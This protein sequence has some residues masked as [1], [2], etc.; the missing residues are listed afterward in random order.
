MSEFVTALL[1]SGGIFVMMMLTQLGRRKY[2]VARILIP[3]A[4]LAYFG[5]TYL[6]DAPL[7]GADLV[8]YGVA[9]LIGAVFAVLA[10]VT[11]K[12]EKDGTGTIW[13]VTGVGFVIT[14]LVGM[15]L[16]VGFVWSV[17]NVDSFRNSFGRWIFENNISENAIAP[18]FVIMAIV[19]VL[20]RVAAVRIRAHRLAHRDDTPALQTVSV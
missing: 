3:I 5:W 13:T 1:I 7:G 15:A 17:D 8:V 10:T 16:R 11:T 9:I 6:H 2:E 14:W 18:F 4:V 19:M 12:L 20:G